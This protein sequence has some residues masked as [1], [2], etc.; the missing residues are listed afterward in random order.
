MRAPVSSSPSSFT[1]SSEEMAFSRATPPPG[2]MPSSTAARVALRASSTRCF[3][4][5]SS[6]S[7]AAPTLMTATLPASLPRRSWAF[8]RSQSLLASSRMARTCPTRASMSRF[9]PLPSMM[10]VSS[11]VE[12]TR[13]A[14]PRSATVTLSSVRPISSEITCAPVSV[15]MSPRL[16]FWRSPKP[17]AFTASTFI[18]PRSLFTASVASASP[19]TSAAMMSRFFDCET[20]FSSSGSSSCTDDSFLSVMSSSGSSISASMRSGLVTK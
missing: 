11:L 6:T 18:V 10:V 4:S 2:T 17:G 12:T 8:S 5:F 19:S 13:R 15:A 3:F 16:S 9:L 7:V 1:R 14:R 20:I